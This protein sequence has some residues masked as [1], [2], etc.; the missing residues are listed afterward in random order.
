MSNLAKTVRT[1][2][3]RFV[4]LDR[5]G[6]IIIEREYLSDPQQVELIPGASEAL[7][8]LRHLRLGLAVVTNHSGVGRGYFDAARVS[9][10]HKRL[11]AL[12][13]ADGPIGMASMSV[14]THLRTAVFVGSPIQ[15]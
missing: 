13:A 9:L 1:K 2:A 3:R 10:V 4:L 6:T 14:P 11:D 12:L 7:R 8:R 5:D 15:G